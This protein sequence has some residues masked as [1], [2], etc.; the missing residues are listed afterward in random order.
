MSVFGERTTN[1]PKPKYEYI[2]TQERALE[3]LASVSKYDL[4]EVDTET[5][6]LVPFTSKIVLVQIGVPNMAYVFDVRNDTD[7]S[8][9]DP[10]AFKELFMNKNVVKLLQNAVFDMKMIK[11][12]WGFYIEN[13]YDTMLVEQLLNLGISEKGAS[14]QALVRKYLGLYMDKEPSKTFSDYNQV[15]KDYQLEYAARDVTILSL[16]R[17]M[18]LT[19]IQ[20]NKFEDVARL[21]FEFVKPLCEMEL[22][23]ITIDTEKWRIIMTEVAK[24]KIKYRDIIAS[25]LAETEDQTSLFGVST[26]NIDSNKQ[27][28]HAL[29]RYGLDIENTDVSTL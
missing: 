12:H 19:D 5:T 7:F 21:E 24:D 27:L 28:L 23:G 3:V 13:I 17:D 29:K 11:H 25:L 6:G 10:K 20:K 16:I 26:I 18:Q 14:L 15:F 2:T 4:I 8:D 1:L 9:I 22:N